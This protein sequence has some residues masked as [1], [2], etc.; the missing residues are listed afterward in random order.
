[1]LWYCPLES[2]PE[3]YT[4]QLSAAKTGWLERNWIKAGIDY[5]RIEGVDDEPG[6]IQLGQV[7]D[8]GRR[9]GHCFQQCLK[10]IQAAN[11][12]RLTSN[13]VIFFDDFWHPGIESLAYTFH[14]LDIRPKMYATCYAQ[15]VDIYDFTYPMRSWMRPFEV[16]IG[17]I[18]DG[19]FVACP[20]LRKLASD[21]APINKIHDVGLVFDS[22]EVKERMGER[23][24]DKENVVIWTSRWD[25]EKN[26]LQF[27]R[28]IDE[29]NRLRGDT[30]VEFVIT[31]S[32]P[33]LRSN[34]GLLTEVLNS[35]RRKHRN[36]KVMEGLS[37]EEYYHQLKR[38]K[39]QFNSAKQDWV[40][41]TLLEAAVAGCY[42]VYPDFN[43]F[44]ETFQ[45]R[46]EFLYPVNEDTVIAE[47]VLSVL[48]DDSLHTLE[49]QASRDWIFKRFD[50][51]WERQA[52]IM[53]LIDADQTSPFMLVWDGGENGPR[54]YH[55]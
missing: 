26:P 53:G 2:Y 24:A 35:A 23:T 4:Y 5:V 42:P 33:H 3:R 11:L 1:M 38:A 51:T 8:A 41:F 18:L 55:D 27:I 17:K 34:S 43:A 32:Q 25:A 31:T 12:G 19:I 36:L 52:S 6:H 40:A 54:S 10:L 20:T 47:K 44:P 7:L 15:S 50:S 21:F 39:V 16:G 30:E 14:Q 28:M 37:K 49:A 13:D 48:R 46:K 45:Y 29:V 22:E 9:T